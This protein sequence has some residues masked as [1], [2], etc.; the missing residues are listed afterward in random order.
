VQDAVLELSEHGIVL[1]VEESGCLQAK[2][3]LKREVSLV[4]PSGVCVNASRSLCVE[5]FVW[6]S[7]AAA[8][9]GI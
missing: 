7:C 3:Y 1:I 4:R 2:V 6:G 5:F 8:V 9:H